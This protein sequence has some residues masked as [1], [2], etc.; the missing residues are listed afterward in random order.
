MT[1]DPWTSGP[2]TERATCLLAPNPGVMTLEGTNTWVLREPGSTD[3]AVVDPGPDDDGHLAAVLEAATAEGGRVTQVL[4][5][6]HHRDHTAG[7]ARLVE[8]SGAPVR[9]GGHGDAF[10]DGE[11]IAVGGLAVEVVATPGHTSDSVSFLVAA[12][13]LLLTGDTVLGRG[14]TVIAGDG[15]LGDYLRSLSA[16]RALVGDGAVER[17]APGHGPAV[18]DPDEFLTGLQEHRTSRLEE[19]R[20]AVQAGAVGIEGLVDAV[21]GP[22]AADR[23]WAAAHSVRAQLD[24]LGI[25]PG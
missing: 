17:L 12:D 10:R 6:H 5:T 7:V 19:I 16:L 13:R 2:L 24:Y 25:H 15:D 20:A 21:Y 23:R 1:T 4:L 8:A 9:G 11:R 18:D 14:T 3:V 22:I